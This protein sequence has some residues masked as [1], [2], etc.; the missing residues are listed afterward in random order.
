MRWVSMCCALTGSAHFVVGITRTNPHPHT[1]NDKYT[2]KNEALPLHYHILNQSF[3]RLFVRPPQYSY[4]W[5]PPSCSGFLTRRSCPV[6]TIVKGRH[7]PFPPLSPSFTV[8]YDWSND[9]DDFLSHSKSI[10]TH[11]GNLV[12]DGAIER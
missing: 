11:L 9:S 2:R 5:L 8:A 6:S 12:N 4:S 10:V 7:C 1:T 3:K